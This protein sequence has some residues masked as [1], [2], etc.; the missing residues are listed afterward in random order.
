MCVLKTRLK[1]NRARNLESDE[2]IQSTYRSKRVYS[3]INGHEMRMQSKL[4]DNIW[5]SSNEIERDKLKDQ[6]SSA[7]IHCTFLLTT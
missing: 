4:G 1:G 7:Q 2:V 5:D 3:A 6:D